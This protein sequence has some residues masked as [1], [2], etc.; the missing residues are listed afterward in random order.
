MHQME[1]QLQ[2]LQGRESLLRYSLRSMSNFGD[3][4]M[5]SMHRV[6]LRPERVPEKNR[7]RPE[8]AR[9]AA[10]RR[11]RPR[12]LPG[13]GAAFCPR[14]GP[15]WI[16]WHANAQPNGSW[17]R[18]LW[19]ST[20]TEGKAFQ[21][22]RGRWRIETM[23]WP[24]GQHAAHKLRPRFGPKRQSTVPPGEMAPTTCWP[25]YRSSAGRQGTS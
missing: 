17:R 9:F 21:S 6:M 18:R 7:C 20:K 3:A 15:C 8:N 14:R 1:R 16:S 13:Y 10:A 4:V 25:R 12:R 5:L 24:R 23:R 19:A 22:H 2:L 11:H